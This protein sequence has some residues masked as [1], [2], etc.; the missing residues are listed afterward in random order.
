ME[1]EGCQR[2]I[3]YHMRFVRSVAEIFHILF[4]RQSACFGDEKY[5][6]T[7]RPHDFPKKLDQYMSLGK[8]V[9]ACPQLLPYH[10]YCIKSDNSDFSFYEIYKNAHHR[11]NYFRIFIVEINLVD[12]GAGT[13]GRPHPP[14]SFCRGELRKKRGGTGAV[15]FLD[16]I[17]RNFVFGKMDE[18]IPIPVVS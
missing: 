3:V 7:N 6:W 17:G 2:K 10:S 5:R 18:I 15:D 4:I 8:I 16:V 11:K 1:Y 9:A 12:G 13:I 14:L